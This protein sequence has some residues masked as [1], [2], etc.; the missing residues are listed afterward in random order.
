MKLFKNQQEIYCSL[1]TNRMRL[2]LQESRNEITKLRTDKKE[3]EDKVN[4]QQKEFDRNLR[5]ENEK[6]QKLT[7]EFKRT[8]EKMSR[9]YEEKKAHYNQVLEALN[10]ERQGRQNSDET[11]YL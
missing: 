8:T 2:E 10:A 4:V 3:L 1:F 7:R 6:Y 5:N 9:Q 11:V